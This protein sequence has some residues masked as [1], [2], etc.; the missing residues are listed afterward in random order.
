MGACTESILIAQ[1]HVLEEVALN[2]VKCN[3]PN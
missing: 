2:K 1:L 3:L